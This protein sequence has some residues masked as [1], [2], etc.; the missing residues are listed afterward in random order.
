MTDIYS[1]L[2]KHGFM[3]R[4][5]VQAERI[6]SIP[7][8]TLRDAADELAEATRDPE[9]QPE[10]STFSHFASLELSGGVG[11]CIS[12]DCRVEK[13]Q[14]L[15]RCAVINSER[16]FVFNPMNLY[17]RTHE[18]D[19]FQDDENTRLRVIGDVVVFR[20][21]QPYIQ[22]G[23]VVPITPESH[24]CPRHAVEFNFGAKA[25]KRFARARRRL[26]DDYLDAMTVETVVKNG[27]FG[28]RC[29]GP[30]PY[31]AHDGAIWFYREQI[32]PEIRA[33]PRITKQLEAGES[34][35]L[36][37]TLKRKLVFHQRLA[38]D[39]V[40]NVHLEAI[41]A[42]TLATRFLTDNDLHVRF[43]EQLT[44]DQERA[45]ANQLAAQYLT[46][47]IPFLNDLDPS[48]ILKLRNREPESF[49]LFRS[50]L[51]QALASFQEEGRA[52]DGERARQIYS[53]VIQPSIAALEVKMRQSRTNLLRNVTRTTVAWIGALSFGTYLGLMPDDLMTAAKVVGATKVGADLLKG[54]MALGDASDNAKAEPFY[55]LWRLKKAAE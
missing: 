50:A 40:A 28:A 1:I 10:S 24:Y 25:G 48:D 4:G 33:Y 23:L 8:A 51:Q 29:S 39:V 26:R 22:A 30:E 19:E 42:Q 52:L 54:A 15:V 16:V 2:A 9:R 21:L 55:F 7:L 31:F 41:T 53:D 34:V 45:R 44:G 17:S 11:R 38:D 18:H 36:S 37:R 20:F 43:L 49:V 35:E 47:A 13:V 32:P 12:P 46:A 3:R 6:A 14:Q 27:V 5:K